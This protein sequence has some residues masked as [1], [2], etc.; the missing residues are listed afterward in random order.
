MTSKD[1]AT[2]IDQVGGRL[3]RRLAPRLVSSAMQP[4]EMFAAKLRETRDGI[5]NSKAIVR[6]TTSGL[7]QGSA[8]PEALS[9]VTRYGLF[10]T[11]K[12]GRVRFKVEKEEMIKTTLF[13]LRDLRIQAFEV[14]H[15]SFVF[16]MQQVVKKGI[17][18]K[19]R[20]LESERSELLKRVVAGFT[21]PETAIPSALYG[22]ELE[23]FRGSVLAS[24]LYSKSP[25]GFEKN[26]KRT[27]QPVIDAAK[28]RL[29][30]ILKIYIDDA[31]V[32]AFAVLN[33]RIQ[34]RRPTKNGS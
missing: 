26:Y 12:E 2:V 32:Y 22:I 1:L 25:T 8:R 24:I 5:R 34:V 16:G 29:A 18:L 4:W 13:L 17:F 27:V 9:L 6:V 11:N 23:M 20:I 10:R 31:I 3:H 33:E 7:V 21:K 15:D 28:K 19:S 30:S 14:G